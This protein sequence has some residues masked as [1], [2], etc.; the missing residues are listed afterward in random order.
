M[1][2]S[3]LTMREFQEIKKQKE[4]IDGIDFYPLRIKTTVCVNHQGYRYVLLSKGLKGKRKEKAIVWALEQFEK[5]TLK[6]LGDIFK[7]E[8]E[9][10]N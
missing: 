1:N 8:N 6:P 3:K 5:D 4:T 10:K 7:T 9:V 2:K